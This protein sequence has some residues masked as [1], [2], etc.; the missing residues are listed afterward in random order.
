MMKKYFTI[1]IISVFCLVGNMAKAQLVKQ[2]TQIED[3]KQSEKD[4]YNC[5]YEKDGVYGACVNE[6]YEFLR[7]KKM[8]AKPIVALIG[9]GVDIE[10]EALKANLWKNPKDKPDGKDNDR[11]GYIDD[12][13]GWNFIGGKDGQVMPFVNREGEREFLR[14]KDKYGN[15]IKDGNIY[16]SF[17]SGK[18]EV[19]PAPQ[20]MK[21][22]EYYRFTLLKESR[23][24]NTYGSKWMT[25]ISADYARLFDKE[26]K[27]KFPD[28]KDIMVSDVVKCCQPEN[29]QDS[30]LRKFMLYAFEMTSNFYKSK[31]WETMYKAYTAEKRFAD[32]EK[33]YELEYQK[34]GNDGREAI[35]GDNYLDINDTKYGNNVLLTADAMIGTMIAGVIAGPR[36]VEG[37]NNPIADQAQIMTLVVQANEGEP[38]LKDMALA[39]RYAV[40][41]GASII[42]LPQQN[43]LYP[44][45]QRQWM[46]EAIRY[47]E[48]KGVLVIVPVHELSRDL[49]EEIFFPNRW[50][51]RGTEFTNL[52][53]VGMSDK[54]GMPSINSNFGEKELDIYAPGVKMLSTCTGDTYQY[55]NGVPMASATIAGIAALIKTYYPKLTGSQIR[56]ILLKTVTSRKGVEVE[57]NITRDGK[58]AVDLY[59]FEQ[60]CLS[61]GIVNALE[62]LKAADKLNGK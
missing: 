18:K 15:I 61:G 30:S 3:K 56:D 40:M 14:L 49:G 16:Y 35:V 7:G 10:H 60:L 51:D 32:A 22:Y 42:V 6:A 12:V 27:Q 37:R 44:E 46:S 58:K 50:M 1:L 5:S 24:A 62:A 45:G 53:T 2:K 59:L 25:C 26:V 19:C 39:I 9:T 34:Y 57:K 17:A 48:Q 31:T 4:W 23:L 41:H 13:N 11:N 36:G 52:M 38:Y 43:T 47:A 21:E 20:D 29:V 8:K 55:G 28:K 54:N 33:K